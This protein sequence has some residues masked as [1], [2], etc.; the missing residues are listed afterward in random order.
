MDV[1]SRSNA[2][3]AHGRQLIAVGARRD[4]AVRQPELIE[5][6]LSND[7]HEH[8]DD[9]AVTRLCPVAVGILVALQTLFNSIHLSHH[10]QFAGSNG[11]A[12]DHGAPV[13]EI[14][15]VNQQRGLGVTET[16]LAVVRSG[17]LLRAAQFYGDTDGAELAH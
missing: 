12:G 1:V 8:L 14:L 13:L 6:R 5:V 10:V 7:L 17:L 11:G 16:T 9:E 15:P 4:G 3:I 2:I